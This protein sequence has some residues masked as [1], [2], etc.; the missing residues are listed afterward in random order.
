MLQLM[1]RCPELRGGL[2]V[3]ARRAFIRPFF[4]RA[5][6]AH[7]LAFT[8]PPLSHIADR[9]RLGAP[10]ASGVAVARMQDAGGADL[11]AIDE[12]QAVPVLSAAHARA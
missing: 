1:S 8:V 2:P 4:G 6:V 5:R 7:H 11:G 12:M 9:V 10:A 3:L